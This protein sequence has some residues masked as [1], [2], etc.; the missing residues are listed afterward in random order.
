MKTLMSGLAFSLAALATTAQAELTVEVNGQEV[1]VASLMDNCKT[2]TDQPEAQVACYSAISKLLEEQSGDTGEGVETPDQAL[3]ALRNLAQYQDGES[4]LTIT[5]AGC[6]IQTTYFANYFHISRRNVSSIDLHHAS[7]DASKLRLDETAAARIRQELLTTGFM[8]AGG[9]AATRGGNAIESDVH[10]FSPK[11]AR[12]TMGEYAS[13]VV[14][15][16]PAQDLGQFP[17]V[18][19]HPA[20]ENTREDIWNA[21][22]AY[23]KACQG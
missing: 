20:R 15:Q 14:S 2:M 22:E 12:A 6:E 1:S 5:G 9:T 7:F 11:S 23:V 10:H 16:L 13:E 17:F 21:F 8:D 19:V 3:E 4:G 18:L